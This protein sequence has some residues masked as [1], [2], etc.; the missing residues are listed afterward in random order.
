MILRRA[1]VREVLL[2]SVAVTLVMLMIFIVVRALGFLRQAAEGMIPVDSIFLLL[3]LKVM[4]YMDV[5]L[6]LMVFVAILMVLDRW[7]RDNETV[8]MAASGYSPGHLL[9]PA[10]F[11]LMVSALVVGGFSFYLSP[12]AVRVGGAIEHEFRTGKEVS[13]IMA[14][15]FTETRNGRGVYF[16]ETADNDLSVYEHVFIYGSDA[17]QDGVVVAATA[18]QEQDSKSGDRFLVLENGV[19]FEGVPGDPAY[20]VIEFESYSIR[21]L[22]DLVPEP[23]VPLR[24]RRNQELWQQYGLVGYGA[25]ARSELHWRLSKVVVLPVMI[26]FALGLGHISPG[27][28]RLPAIIAAL[29]IYF[30]YTNVA[31]LAVATIRKSTTLSPTIGLWTLHLVFAVVAIYLFWCRTTNRPLLS[32]KRSPAGS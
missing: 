23:P 26:L 3:L 29:A 14:G 27:R 8:I 22:P 7:S 9:K 4:T 18:R 13:G 21:L 28:G 30:C 10:A 5:I 31:G 1:F 19:R 12:L 24:G 6:P 32:L 16:V 2:T 25:L 17:T 20:R 15:V 11:L